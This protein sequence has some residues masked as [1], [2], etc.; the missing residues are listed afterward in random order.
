MRP[1]CFGSEL[2]AV[3][4][5]QKNYIL[6]I[7]LYL[8]YTFYKKLELQSLNETFFWF[9]S[10]SLKSCVENPPHTSEI[11]YILW[12]ARGLDIKYDRVGSYDVSS[13]L[14]RT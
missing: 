5:V 3:G 2:K 7:L 11:K 1:F 10:R 4:S 14:M 13:I 12:R 9:L 6:N 8:Y